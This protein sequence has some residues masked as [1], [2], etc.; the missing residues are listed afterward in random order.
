MENSILIIPD[1]HGRTFWKKAKTAILNGYEIIF[2]G[3]Y[4]DPYNFEGITNEETYKNF[5]EILEFKIKYK[6]QITLLLGNH[7]CEYF[8]KD[9]YPCR[10]D[11]ELKEEYKRIFTNY[12]DLFDLVAY[13][14]I[15]GNKYSFS[16]SCITNG[17]LSKIDK[18]NILGKDFREILHN[19]QSLYKTEKY[20]TLNLI[21]KDVS[22]LRGGNEQFGSMIWSNWDEIKQ[23]DYEIDDIFQIF[24]HSQQITNEMLLDI[25]KYGKT[26]KLANPIITKWFACL[27]CK[28]IFEIDCFGNLKKFNG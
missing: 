23:Y 18:Y 7:D 8:L 26:N 12:N 17:W 15:N 1:I 20:E 2:L 22:Y 19:L 4:L 3:D 9:I 5:Q 25:H 14:S 24:G 21:L 16:H 11:L 10:Q 13:R 27:D 6:K 28:Q